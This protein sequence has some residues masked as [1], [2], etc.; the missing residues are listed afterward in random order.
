M[1]GDSQPA[2]PAAA[3]AFQPVQDTPLSGHA[4]DQF[5]D[6]ATVSDSGI[7][8]VSYRREADGFMVERAWDG[9]VLGPEVEVLAIP[10]DPATGFWSHMAAGVVG[11]HGYTYSPTHPAGIMSVW[12][13]AMI[14][15][16]A[17]PAVVAVPSLNFFRF[18]KPQ[19]RCANVWDWCLRNG[20]RPWHEI[21]WK[22]HG[23]IPVKCWRDEDNP[24]HAIP[25]QGREFHKFGSIPLPALP[26]VDTQIL[27]FRVPLGYDGLLYS[28][29]CKYQ[30][31]GYVNGSGDLIWRLRQNEYW[32]KS[33]HAI[34]TEL[35]D[36]T[37]YL[38]L[39]EYIRVY[40]GQ[41]V[42]AYGWLSPLSGMVGG[43][44]IAALQGWYYPSQLA[45]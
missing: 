42:R 15:A 31:M 26:G 22:R 17:P 29:L 19:F 1:H 9:A 38:Q 21:D 7:V 11:S 8:Y 25:E 33:F 2:M 30:G 20:E 41:T 34:P 37:A 45:R 23:R 44:M 43:S 18:G 39:D 12:G 32:I 6:Y 13:I 14:A 16:P 5:S 40:S 3:W 27:S 28:V 10:W 36:Y 4:G 24:L 35:G